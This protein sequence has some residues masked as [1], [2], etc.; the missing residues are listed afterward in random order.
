MS[1]P[2]WNLTPQCQ[3]NFF[4]HLKIAKKFRKNLEPQYNNFLPKNL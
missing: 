2:L 4:L 1:M 3:F